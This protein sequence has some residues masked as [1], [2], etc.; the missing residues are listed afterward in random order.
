PGDQEGSV[1]F[2]PLMQVL[3]GAGYGTDG[4]RWLVIEAE[5]DPG[6]RNPLLYQTLGLATLKRLAKESGLDKG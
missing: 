6:L 5:Q 2:A 3:A 1:D 4:D